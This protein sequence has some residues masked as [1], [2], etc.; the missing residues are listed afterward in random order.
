MSDL[1][2]LRE[3]TGEFLPPPFDDLVTVS[4]KRRRRSAMGAVAAAAAAVIVVIAVAT[5]V[6]GPP[7]ADQGPIAPTPS[8]TETTAPAEPMVNGRI[9]SGDDYLGR[10]GG[11]CD[12]CE[13]ADALAFDQGTGRLLLAWPDSDFRHIERLRVIGRDGELAELACP[14]DFDCGQL[15]ANPL[16]TFGPG[17]DEFS[18]EVAERKI[19]VVGYDGAVR[20]TVDVSAA[21]GDETVYGIAWSPDGRRLALVT[22]AAP[23]T[24]RGF[25][26][27]IWLVDPDGHDPQLVY[28]ASSTEALRKGNSSFAYVG[29]L[30][31]SPDGKRLGFIEEH[32]LGHRGGRVEQRSIQAVSLLVPEPGQGGLGAAR[33]LYDYTTLPYYHAALVWSPDGAR[34]AV[35]SFGQV[36]ELSADDGSV[37]ARHPFVERDD[38]TEDLP[39][40]VWPARH[41]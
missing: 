9:Q 1:D 14:D 16:A 35:R 32:E 8:P 11:P 38:P 7:Q 34:V 13:E 40:L 3:L 36:L 10:V 4:R 22:R 33:T 6:A 39:P 20:R 15:L 41:R 19:Q 2:V 18:V 24:G 25:V 28:T 27:N 31:W 23:V 26:N 37:L 29:S 12:G 21:L 30:V 17:A 5:G